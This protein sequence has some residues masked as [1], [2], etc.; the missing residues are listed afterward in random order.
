MQQV[1]ESALP[2]TPQ[3][4]VAM[5]G[6]MAVF[7]CKPYDQEYLEKAAAALNLDFNFAFFEATLEADTVRMAD[8]FDAVCI[9]VN[10]KVD[11]EVV[12][13]LASFGVKL[14]AL[15]CAGFNNV[16]VEKATQ[17]GITVARVPAYSPNA[18][19]EHTVTLMLSLNRRIPQAWSKTRSGNFSLVGQMGFDMIGRRVGIIG[20]GHIGSIVAEILKR[21]FKCDIV[22]Y[23]VYE[24]PRLTAAEPEGLGVRYVDLDELLRTSDIISLHAPLTESTYHIINEESISK[25]KP[26]VMIINTSRGGLIHT[27]SLI[28]G[29]KDKKIG[30]AGVD[31]YCKEGP[32]MFQDLSEEGI[33]DDVFAR[34]MTFPNVIVTAHQ[35]FF[36][37][38]AMTQIAQ[39][40]LRNAEGVCRGSGPPKQY[41]TLDTVVRPQPSA[42][43]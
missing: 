13:A 38:E 10:D 28:N 3:A 15:R 42:K 34:L 31:V 36:T 30:H 43:L 21:G 25:M 5:A 41:G 17:L 37:V 16:D 40:T 12:A 6:S 22:A 24:N 19:A 35:A 2:P 20:T 7:S 8:G 23:D 26:G 39:T 4:Q 18:V 32:Y 1:G 33:D 27:Q 14:I 29:L 9:F 11:G